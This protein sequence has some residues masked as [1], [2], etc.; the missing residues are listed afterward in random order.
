M[1][2]MV[3][4]SLLLISAVTLVIKR[5]NAAGVRCGIGS[6]LFDLGFAY[7]W[8]SEQSKGRAPWYELAFRNPMVGM[9][10]A[11]GLGLTIANAVID[12]R[13]KAEQ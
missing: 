2:M 13:K 1:T 4:L 5:N 3:S 7:F 10:L 11:A 6:M 8:F 12:Y 9:I